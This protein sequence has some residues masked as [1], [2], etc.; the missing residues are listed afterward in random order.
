MRADGRVACAWLAASL[1]G[2]PILA[3]P[4]SAEPAPCAA[5]VSL[6]PESAI[7]GQ[8]VLYRVRILRRADVTRVRWVRPPAFPNVRAEWLPGRAED[9]KT[10]RD[11]ATYHVREDHR[12]LF[13]PRAGRIV[14]P[15]FEL[16]CTLASGAAVTA[17]VQSVVL[18]ALA[19]PATRRP[20]DFA[21]LIG[22]LQV[23]VSTESSAISLGGGRN[24]GLTTSNPAIAICQ[25]PRS[26]AVSMARTRMVMRRSRRVHQGPTGPVFT[27]VGGAAPGAVTLLK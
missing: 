7:V 4:S 26:T 6:A 17:E 19:P 24:T 12:A 22:S 5:E 23:R 18:E 21:G 2:S 27:V 15:A 20:A 16:Q 9:M 8:Q 3:L 14:L 10:T 1:L 11:G 25:I 13:A